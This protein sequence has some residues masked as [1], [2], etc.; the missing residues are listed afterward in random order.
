MST[1]VKN[2]RINASKDTIINDEESDKNSLHKSIVPFLILAKIV[3]L[4][5]IQGIREKNSSYLM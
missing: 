4:F 3:G 5:P 1:I 2:T